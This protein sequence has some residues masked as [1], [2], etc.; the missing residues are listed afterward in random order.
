MLAG[1]AGRETSRK[2]ARRT[3]GCRRQQQSVGFRGPQR[4][5]CERDHLCQVLG[6]VVGLRNTAVL[7][8]QEEAIGVMGRENLMAEGLRDRGRFSKVENLRLQ[9]W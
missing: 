5:R 7:G 8:A 4:T 2:W 3:E 9:L 6:P 1:A